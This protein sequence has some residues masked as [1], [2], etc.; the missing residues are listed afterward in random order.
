MG[1]R[2]LA[3]SLE[4]WKKILTNEQK[5]RYGKNPN[6]TQFYTRDTK[7]KEYLERK[8]MEAFDMSAFI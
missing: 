4:I 1:K 5:K 6:M 3:S 8:E 2:P 7:V